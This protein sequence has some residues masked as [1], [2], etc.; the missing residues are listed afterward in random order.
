MHNQQASTFNHL[1]K[2]ESPNY[3]RTSLAGAMMLGFIQGRFYR[4][5]KSYCLNLL[6]TYNDGCVGKCAYCGL[7]RSRSINEPWFKKSF[8]RVDWPIV[9]LEDVIERIRT[10]TCDLERVCISMITNGRAKSDTLTIVK[11][12]RSVF[13]Q[14]SVLTTPTIVDEAWLKEVKDLGADMIGVA[15]D[16]ATKT[17][18]DKLRGK[19]VGAP[20]RWEQYW[21]ILKSA[22]DIFGKFNVGIHLIVGLGETEREIV[23]TIQHAYDMGALTHLFSFF[24]EE[25]S[26]MEHHPQPPIGSYRRIQLARYLINNALTRVDKMLFDCKGR[27]VNFGLDDKEVERFIN[28]GEP[29]MT[30]GCRSKN[31]ENA[32]NRPYSNSTPYQA[33]IGEIRN[34][35]FKPEPKDIE[36]IRLQLFDYSDIPVKKWIDSPYLIE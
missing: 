36:I 16:A 25:G 35:P 14:I 8:I 10:S 33:L 5:A 1:E 11:R 28:L 22:I 27:I 21:S 30:S 7:S 2:F 15:I 29:F 3:V 20:H 31:R 23:M 17:L 32:C 19:N 26:P 13:D 24:P 4:D 34:Y 12:I 9:N 18:F 6:L